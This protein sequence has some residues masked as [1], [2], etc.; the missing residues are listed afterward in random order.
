MACVP[1]VANHLLPTVL[2]KFAHTNPAVRVKII[3]ESARIVLDSVLDGSAD[4]GLNFLGSQE[5][6]LDFQAIRVEPYMVVVPLGHPLQQHRSLRWDA[7]AQETLISVSRNSGNRLLIDNAFAN[8]KHRPA[9][10]Y[11]INHVTGAMQLVAAGLGIAIVPGLAL[12]D[13]HHAG[14]AGIPLTDP[15]IARTLG[16]ITRKGDRMH[17]HAQQLAD[18][19]I[20]E[21][22]N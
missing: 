11:E 1:S 21:V 10:H 19:L 9:I 16:L 3:D 12:S 22:Q 18:L 7:L 20:A 15:A 13:A 4:F 2:K 8:A 14:L 6:D 17:A 5:A